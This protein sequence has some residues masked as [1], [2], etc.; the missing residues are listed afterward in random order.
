MA[1]LCQSQRRNS[2]TNFQTLFG[3]YLHS[4]GVKRRQLD[5]LAQFGITMSYDTIKRV[6]KTLADRG[7]DSIA[8]TAS[9]PGVITAYDN[10][11]QMEGVKEQRMDSNSTF[12]SVT[13]GEIMEG[14]DI[15]DGGLQQS[16]LDPTVQLDIGQVV[17]AP[18]NRADD[19]E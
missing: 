19:V 4:K 17:W 10:F 12:K 8:I 2:A 9:T 3:L 7:Q 14:R 13:T 6:V 15:P 16:M 5:V 11:E 18:G 1:I